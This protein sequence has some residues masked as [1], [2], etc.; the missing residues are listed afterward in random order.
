MKRIMRCIV[1]YLVEI[2]TT[3]LLVLGG[4]FLALAGALCY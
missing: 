2:S 3:V 4:I 1:K